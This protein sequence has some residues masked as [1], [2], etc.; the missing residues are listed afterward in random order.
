MEERSFKPP[1][2]TKVRNK[3]FG[4]STWI[5]SLSELSDKIAEKEEEFVEKAKKHLQNEN[6][7][8]IRMTGESKFCDTAKEGDQFFHIWAEKDKK[9]KYFHSLNT[10]LLVEKDVECTRLYYDDNRTDENRIPFSKLEKTQKKLNLDKKICKLS[11]RK[12][13]D[14]DVQK[15]KALFQKK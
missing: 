12:V 2:E 11:M 15:L 9:R 3:T 1:I 4:N 7:T 13:T 14:N 8:Y 10:I 5:I 6:V